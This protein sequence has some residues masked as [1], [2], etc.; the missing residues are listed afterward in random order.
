[1]LLLGCA[2]LRTARPSQRGTSPSQNRTVDRTGQEFKSMW[3]IVFVL[4]VL[5]SGAVAGET[6]RV[7]Q[8]GITITGSG[9]PAVRAKSPARAASKMAG[10]PLHP[11]AKRAAGGPGNTGAGIRQPGPAPAM[12]DAVSSAGEPSGLPRPSR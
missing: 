9:N 5:S 1:L 7:L 8:V 11:T 12:T 3:R 6:K 4:C 10:S 2:R